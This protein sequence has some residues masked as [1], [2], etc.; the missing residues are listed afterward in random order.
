MSSHKNVLAYC[1]TWLHLGFSA[2]LRIWQV[3]GS[4]LIFRR[5]HPPTESIEKSN[6]EYRR[7][8][9]ELSHGDGIPRV[10]GLCQYGVS[11]RCLEGLWVVSRKCYLSMSPSINY[12][13]CPPSKISRQ[14]I[15]CPPF[16]VYTF[17]L[18]GA[19]PPC[20]SLPLPG[21]LAKLRIW[22]VQA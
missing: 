7:A 15:R 3:P 20:S 16:S 12:L 9:T 11:R 19:P 1:H 17:F 22:K 21:F 13:G 5:N 14:Y 8:Q 2:E 18:Y 10:S 4:G 6:K